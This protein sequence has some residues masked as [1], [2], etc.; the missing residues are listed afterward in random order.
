MKI[1]DSSAW[2]AVLIFLQDWE[3]RWCSDTLCRGRKEEEKRE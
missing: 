1:I 3:K 2:V